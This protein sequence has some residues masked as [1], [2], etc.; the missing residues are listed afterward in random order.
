[1]RLSIPPPLC[2]TLPFVVCVYARAWQKAYRVLRRLQRVLASPHGDAI[3][4][5]LLQHRVSLGADKLSEGLA[6]SCWD[7]NSCTAL[8]RKAWARTA[9]A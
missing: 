3:L 2:D 6:A 4:A 7:T 9:G 8:W 5:G 1:M